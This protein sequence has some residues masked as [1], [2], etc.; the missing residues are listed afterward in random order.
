MNDRGIDD[1]RLAALLDGRLDERERADLLARLAQSDEDYEVLADSA[2]VL[3]ELEAAGVERLRVSETAPPAQPGEAE[4]PAEREMIPIRPRPARGWR[5][6][7]ARWLALA[8]VLAGVALVP[9]LWSRIHPSGLPPGW[10]N[11]RPWATTRGAGDLLTPEARAVRL[12]ALLADLEVA[13]QSRDSAATSLLAAQ[14]EALLADVPASGPIT[15]IYREVGKRAADR[16]GQ[17]EGRLRQGREAVG[18]LVAEDLVGLGAWTE[19]ARLAAVRRDEEFFRTR[20]T[21]A[22]LEGA[23][24]LPSLPTPARAVV[25]RIRNATSTREHLDWGALERDLTQLLAATA[26]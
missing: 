15:A 17:L 3:Q 4:R 9:V 14:I 22:V 1:E 25:E 10:I 13:V 19:T 11:D 18:T 8:A 6:P 24:N 23:A 5:R 26:S 21:R 16:P 20:E 7:G 12:G 2:G